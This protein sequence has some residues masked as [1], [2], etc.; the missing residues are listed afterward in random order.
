MTGSSKNDLGNDFFSSAMP[1]EEIGALKFL[2]V[3]HSPPLNN[4]LSEIDPH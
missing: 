4:A 1:K 3:Y 2:K